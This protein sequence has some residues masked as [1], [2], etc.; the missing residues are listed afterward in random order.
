MKP[1]PGEGTLYGILHGP[2]KYTW[3][4]FSSCSVVYALLWT[5]FISGLSSYCYSTTGEL[6]LLSFFCRNIL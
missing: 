5:T 3:V 1:L 6:I 2:V 4:P